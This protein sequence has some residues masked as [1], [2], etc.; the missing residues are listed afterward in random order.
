MPKKKVIQK[1]KDGGVL[2]TAATKIGRAAGRIAALVKRGKPNAAPTKK[3]KL[4]TAGSPKKA[5]K[6]VKP[7][8]RKRS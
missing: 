3:A 1:Q 5:R 2:V 4:K 6:A 7:G 8:A